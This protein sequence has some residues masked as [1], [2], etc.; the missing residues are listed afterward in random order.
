MAIVQGNERE[1]SGE[2]SRDELESNDDALEDCHEFSDNASG[3]EHEFTHEGPEDEL[4]LKDDASEEGRHEFNDDVPRKEDESKSCSEVSMYE[5]DPD[6]GESDV[7]DSDISTGDE[8][9]ELHRELKELGKFAS[10]QE[11]KSRLVKYADDD[12]KDMRQ[13]NKQTKLLLGI[14]SLQRRLSAEIEALKVKK[15]NTCSDDKDESE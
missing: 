9:K 3:D 14:V 4:E 12:E 6:E 10:Y 1:S 11:A 7:L 13:A 15:K 2:A 5:D 8:M